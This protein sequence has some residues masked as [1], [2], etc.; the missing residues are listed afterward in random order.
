MIA[1][2]KKPMCL[3]MSKTVTEFLL[4]LEYNSRNSIGG[5]AIKEKDEVIS[6]RN[7]KSTYREIR[8][9]HKIQMK[10]IMGNSHLLE[11]LAP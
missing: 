11:G 2:C 10:I 7:I 9:K 1:L 6:L 5:R 4:C 3:S 8:K